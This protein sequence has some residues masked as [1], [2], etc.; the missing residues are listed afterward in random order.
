VVQKVSGFGLHEEVNS[1]YTSGPSVLDAALDLDP[2][3]EMYEC[4][5]DSERT[6]HEDAVRFEDQFSSQ[7]P[8]QSILPHLSNVPNVNMSACF[9]DPHAE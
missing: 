5:F 6:M 8:M 3:L 2:S 9:Q 1:G 4:G 7:L